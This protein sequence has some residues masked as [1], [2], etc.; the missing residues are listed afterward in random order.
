MAVNFVAGNDYFYR[1]TL[2]SCGSDVRVA[3]L[4]GNV[5]QSTILFPFTI[6]S[7]AR[8]PYAQKSTEG[9]LGRRAKKDS[10]L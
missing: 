10:V 3:R 4:V 1:F 7:Y 5:L 2:H 8:A 6:V 9:I